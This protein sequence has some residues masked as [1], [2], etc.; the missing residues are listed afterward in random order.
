MT[1]V[2]RNRGAPVGRRVILGMLGLGAVGVV[3][4][5]KVADGVSSALSSLGGSG[6]VPGV[7]GFQIYTVTNG[8][9]APPL[10]YHL[11]VDGLVANRLSL[12]VDELRAMPAT[13]L[14]KTFQCVTGWRVPDVHWTGV[15]LWHLLQVAGLTS[16]AKA[17]HFE[18]FDGVYTESLTLDQARLDDIIVAYDML[19]APVS[20]EHGGPLRLYVAPM[21]GYK[22]IK[23]L[24]RV[25]V[26]DKM[27]S[28]FW[29]HYGYA[30]NGWVGGSNG[31]SGS[32]IS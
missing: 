3:A 18:S 27:E 7:G 25:I 22:S 23:W 31:L 28:G 24:S 15:R 10:D 19:G 2:V 1:E 16:Q 14:V 11:A 17:V 32:P 30:L 21:Y 6:L 13:R 8:F 5:A 26:T 4:G 12:T 20:R 29:E 9:P